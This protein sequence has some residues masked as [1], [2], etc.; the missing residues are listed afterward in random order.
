MNPTDH[1]PKYDDI[2]KSENLAEHDTYTEKLKA[3]PQHYHFDPDDVQV[4]YSYPP[5]VMSTHSDRF[6]NE[7]NN[8]MTSVRVGC[9]G[10]A[11]CISED[12]PS[13]QNEEEDCENQVVVANPSQTRSRTTICFLWGARLLA[14]ITILFLALYFLD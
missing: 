2:T 12:C 8:Y 7:L 10:D 11:P 5:S 14:L 9:P 6:I 1:P 4:T 13:N 3:L